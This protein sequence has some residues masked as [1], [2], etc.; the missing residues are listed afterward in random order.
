MASR[1]V[2]CGRARNGAWRLWTNAGGKR[3]LK[4]RRGNWAVRAKHMSTRERSPASSSPTPRISRRASRGLG[5][6]G[7]G[8]QIIEEPHAASK[9]GSGENPATPQAAQAVDLGET[10]GNDKRVF[11]DPGDGAADGKAERR[12]L[13][14]KHFEIDL[15]DQHSHAR[16]MS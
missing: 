4:S 12:G 8:E 11:V 1:C 14:K 5:F 15:V 2:P 10:A 13:V 16:A 6:G 7:G 9:I 3:R